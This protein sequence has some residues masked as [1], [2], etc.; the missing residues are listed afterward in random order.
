MFTALRRL[1]SRRGNPD[2]AEHH[3]GY[4]AALIGVE[5]S[6]S[7]GFSRQKEI[8]KCA[9]GEAVELVP[10][11]DEEHGPN[12]VAVYRRKTRRRLGFL[13]PDAADMFATRIKSGAFYP[14]TVYEK[15]GGHAE[16]PTLG[17]RVRIKT[18]LIA[19][20]TD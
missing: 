7:D 8:R 10:E 13:P 14:A 4:Y 5:D 9:V 11:P 6:S 3:A 2:E 15:T 16:G 18:R 19:G 12:A 1:L 17:L 20:P